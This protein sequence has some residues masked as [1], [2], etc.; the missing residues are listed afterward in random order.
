MGV[1]EQDTRLQRD[2]FARRAKPVKI[3]QEAPSAR[4]ERWLAHRLLAGVGDPPVGIQLWDGTRVQRGSIRYMLRI[5]DR[6]ALWL[7]V[8]DPAYQFGELYSQ[9]RIE[10]EG[11]TAA[12]TVKVSWRYW[13]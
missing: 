5:N 9:G 8:S 11:S 13:M 6:K 4:L 3:E 10:V 1:Q 7:L 12:T 2:E